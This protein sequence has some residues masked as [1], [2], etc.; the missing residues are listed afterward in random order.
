MITA[1]LD[2]LG[3]AGPLASAL[4]GRFESRPEQ[5]AMAAAV[6]ETMER[7]S[8]LLVEAGTGVGKS[9]AY[10][11][12]AILRCV[13]RNERV[14]V[15]TNT[16]ALQEQLVGRDIPMLRAALEGAGVIPHAPDDGEGDPSDEPA[17]GSLRAPKDADS[18][19]LRPVLV[20]GRSNYVSIRR[21]KLASERQ[22]ALFSGEAA[23]VQLHQIEDWAYGTTD[24]TRSTLPRLDRPEVWTHVESDADNC[25]GAKCPFNGRCFYQNA[26]RAME[27]GNLLV[28]NHALFFADLALRSREGPE[29]QPG[30]GFLPK[31]NHVV[32]DEAHGVE[33]AAAEHLGM[34]L[35]EGRVLFLLRTLYDHRRHKGYLAQLAASRM[36]AGGDGVDRAIR[37]AYQAGDA[38]AEF[39]ENWAGAARVLR[40]GR[41]REPGVVA[42][43]LSP[44]FRELSLRLAALRESVKGDAD[45]FEL[46]AYA[47][48]AADIAA[49]ASAFVAQSIPG[50]VYWVEASTG[51][52]R[53]GGG[54]HRVRRVA[55]A[56]APIDVAPILREALFKQGWSV[57]LTS[58]TLATGE[59]AQNPVAPSGRRTPAP[60]R[61]GPPA[62]RI[63]VAEGAEFGSDKSLAS[64]AGDDGGSAVDG[65]T[66]GSTG[67]RASGPFA[68]VVS[69]LGC[70][71][72]RTL[73]LG[74]PFD[75]ARQM[76]VV[77]ERD[78][79]DPRAAGVANGSATSPGPNPP[80]ASPGQR[81][82]LDPH[83]LLMLKHLDATDGG[84]F[85]LFNS[86]TALRRAASA[87]AGP[88]RE[89]SM[90]M[91]VHEPEAS[92]AEL[93][94]RFKEDAR[95]VLLGAASF[96]QGVD[97][98]GRALRNVIIAQLPFEPP[99]RPL[100]EA[101]LELISSRGGDPFRDDSLPRAVLRFK[102]GV[103]RL[104][105]SRSDT[106]RVVVLDPRIVTK[107]YGRA[108]LRALPA[109]VR[110]RD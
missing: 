92:R 103:G 84:A 12:P 46:N 19:P 104:I 32:L 37:L 91:L 41:V 70:E 68:L 83:T 106:G 63:V 101:R 52:G 8:H 20:K 61:G 30:V 16:I 40:N 11:V 53:A 36:F 71:G 14:V 56:A 69:R 72:A 97:V 98:P 39:F 86:F 78:A 10:L 96:W 93:L 102:Q 64:M 45:K 74:S 2:I 31:Y 88:L 99:D 89:R 80:T 79:P 109:G 18:Y 66:G 25:M 42:D 17:A 105:R 34:S 82:L 62:A 58:A 75:F 7:R 35:T 23:R 54:G 87:L 110:L 67:G 65:A 47:R 49:S 48:R 15:A 3:P 22:A 5:L 59:E 77:V 9:F 21:L 26:R 90:P 6:A 24:G 94:S 4:G 107:G 85:I 1:A 13:T 57:V 33:D 28:C 51:G 73:L 55:L 95:S 44:A 60:S 100:T 76:E 38:A 27:K 81:P 108:F 50:C 29:G 43:T